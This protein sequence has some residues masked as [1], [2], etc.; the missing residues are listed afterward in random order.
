MA[1]MVR[2]PVRAR[3]TG[4]YRLRLEVVSLVDDLPRAGLPA[5]NA[6]ALILEP[7]SPV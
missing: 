4:P 3:P 6:L 7:Q 5:I 2:T 1:W